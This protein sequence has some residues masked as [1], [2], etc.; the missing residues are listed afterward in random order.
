[1]SKELK[2][3]RREEMILL[4]CKDYTQK[5]IANKLNTSLSFIE[6]EFY[7]IKSIFGATTLPGLVFEYTK[8]KYNIKNE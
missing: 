3:K 1:M 8:E 2:L 5:E 7:I 6:K 4:L